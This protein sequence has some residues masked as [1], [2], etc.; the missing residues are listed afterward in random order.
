MESFE[1]EY[2]EKVKNW[3]F[4][5]FKIEEEV[6]TD[7]N[8]YKIL[9]ENTNEN[10]KILDLGTGGGEKLL[11]YFPKA[12]EIIG[13]DLSKE[14]IETANKNLEK[15][16]RNDVKFMVMDNLKMETAKNYFDVVVARHTVIDPNQI[17]DSLKEGG[18]LIIR[19]VDKLDCWDLKKLF[20]KG[21][22]YND[23]KSLSQ[24]DYEAVMDAGF[25]D[26]EL[27]PIYIREYFKTKEAF[28]AFMLKVP[29]LYNFSE[30]SLTFKSSKLDLNLLDEY[31]KNNTKEKGIILKRNYYGITARK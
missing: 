22:A 13:T 10:S 27:V 15:S 26:V 18:L 23:T 25:K 14:M 16:G 8:M 5:Y 29:I 4:S 1:Y 3:D 2:Y 9:K 11:E 24:M 30:E 12:N 20:G 28:I 6:L 17:Y 21:Q 19:G 31:I 7:W